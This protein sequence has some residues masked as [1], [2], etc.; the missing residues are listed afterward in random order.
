MSVEFRGCYPILATPFCPGGEIDE[1]S[2]VRLVRHLR[3]VGLPGFTMFGLASE[4][5]KLSDAD[6]KALIEAAFD[7]RVPGTDH[8]RLRDGPQPGGRNEAGPAGRAGRR[9]RAHAVAAVLSRTVGGR[10]APACAGGGR[11]DLAPDHGLVC[12]SP[13]GDEEDR[14]LLPATEPG[15]AERSLREGRG[16]AAGTLDLSDYRWL[17]RHDKVLRRLRWSAVDR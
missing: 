6:R 10:L 11:G 8:H 5:Y 16:R 1:E 15:G 17:R 14:R 2:V 4:F 12:P 7:A 13:D 9:R 3:T